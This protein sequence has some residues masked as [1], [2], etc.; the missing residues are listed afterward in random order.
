M[1]DA[2]VAVAVVLVVVP[3]TL[4]LVYGFL[5]RATRGPGHVYKRLR[6]EA[7]NPPRGA[8]RMPTIYQYFGYVLIFVALDPIFMLLFVLPAAGSQW[9]KII[10]LSMVSVAAILPPVVYA[11]KYAR[12]REYWSLN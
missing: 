2:I 5:S 12:R 6:F 3:L 11:A 1:Y 4:L 7:G 8:A 10:L 9:H